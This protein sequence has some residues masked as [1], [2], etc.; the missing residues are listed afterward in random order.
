MVQYFY[1]IAN[2]TLREKEREKTNMRMILKAVKHQ[3]YKI[4][5]LGRTFQIRG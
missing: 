3:S 4:E 5:P 2:K 1:L